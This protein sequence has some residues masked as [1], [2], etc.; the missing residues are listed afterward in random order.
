MATSEGLSID[1]TREEWQAAQTQSTF[2]GHVV[3][4]IVVPT[5]YNS[6]A[7]LESLGLT[8][9]C[10]STSEGLSID[11]TREEW[12][13]AQTQS[14][15]LGHV[16]QQIVVQTPYNSKAFLESLGLTDGC[17]STSQGN[18]LTLTTWEMTHLTTK[19]ILPSVCRA[20]KYVTNTLCRHL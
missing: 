3:Q 5:P 18:Y 17:V 10:V 20:R 15:F 1:I 8:D 14:T 9:R 16:V 6:K 13:A 2:L 7:F 12:Q 19:Q 4:Q 11:V